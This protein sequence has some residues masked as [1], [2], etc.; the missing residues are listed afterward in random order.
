MTNGAERP[1]S[2]IRVIE[3]AG[4]GTVPFAAMLLAD[5][6]ADVVRI[7]RPGIH[8]PQNPIA[9]RNR[10]SIML[11]LKDPT[12]NETARRIAAKADVLIEGFRP[13][14]M[15]R[16]GLGP[17]ILLYQ[18]PGLIYGRVTGW[19]QDGPLAQTAGHDI[20][21]IALAGALEPI[22]RAGQPPTPPLNLVGDYGGG[23]L[24]LV[25]G[26]LAALIERGRSGYGQVIDAAIVDGAASLIGALQGYALAGR[27]KVERGGTMSGEAPN[28]RCYECADGRLIALGCIE[29]RFHQRLFELIGWPR[30]DWPDLNDQTTWPTTG[31][32]LSAVFA[33]KPRAAWLEMLEYEEVC[34]TPVLGFADVAT[35]PHIAARATYV[36]AFGIRQ[37]APAPRFSR[38]P[39]GLD[40]P[41]PAIGEG[42]EAM[43]AAWGVVMPR[44]NGS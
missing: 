8:P 13:G 44:D 20:N 15:E 31:A 7:D 12:D 35:H 17:D 32:R 6:G 28:F 23:A 16:L 42:G 37:P 30:D 43:V 19:G 34:V 11:D 9:S 5:L 33:T 18:N 1:L 26:I 40:R 41:A 29:P 27:F 2:G 14:V 36:E 25:L 21:Y 22:G 4:I 38:T 10:T 24:Y 39:G 3:V